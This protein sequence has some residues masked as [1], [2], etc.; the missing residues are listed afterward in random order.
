M[1][2]IYWRFLLA[3]ITV[4][5]L[6]VMAVHFLPILQPVLNPRYHPSVFWLVAMLIATAISQLTS[7]GLV[8]A[9]FGKNMQLRPV[10][11][12]RINLWL[13]GLFGFLTAFALIVQAVSSPTVWANYKLYFQPTM[14]TLGPLVAGSFTLHQVKHNNLL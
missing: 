4:F 9:F 2:A 7:Q 3:V 12:T 11:W 1:W 8:H 6:T 5:L 13:F 14:L 10:F